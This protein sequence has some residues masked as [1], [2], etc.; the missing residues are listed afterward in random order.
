[1]WSLLFM[2]IQKISKQ[3]R[4][5]RKSKLGH[6]ERKYENM[7]GSSMPGEGIEPKKRRVLSAIQ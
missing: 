4:L 1:M 7:K 5:Q 6:Q 3:F 2:G